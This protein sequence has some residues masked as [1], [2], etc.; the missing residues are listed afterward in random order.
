MSNDFCKYL[1]KRLDAIQSGIDA[2]LTRDLGPNS[3]QEASAALTSWIPDAADQEGGPDTL[4]QQQDDVFSP[5]FSLRESWLHMDTTQLQREREGLETIYQNDSGMMSF[6][7][8]QTPTRPHWFIL[9]SHS[10]ERLCWDF[11]GLVMISLELVTTPVQLAFSARETVSLLILFWATLVYWT[12]DIPVHF[13]TAHYRA[14]LEELRLEFIAKDYMKSWLI[15][16]L[17]IVGVDWA[18]VLLQLFHTASVS[19][20][21][22]STPVRLLRLFRVLRLLRIIKLK[23]ILDALEDQVRSE[24]YHIGSRIF[25]FVI[26]ILCVC[27]F[28]A[29]GWYGMSAHITGKTW[30]TSGGF[31]SVSLSYRYFTALHWSLTQ[32]T[33]ASVDVVPHNLEERIYAVIVLLF[34]LVVFSSFLSSIT[35][36]MTQLRNISS[37]HE[38]SLSLLRRFLYHNQVPADLTIRI[39]RYVEHKLFL[40]KG[41]VQEKDVKLIKLLSPPLHME[42]VHSIRASTL[43]SHPFIRCYDEADT[44]AMKCVCFAAISSLHTS[45]RDVLFTEAT[46]DD[47]MLFVKHG[48]LEYRNMTDISGS[49]AASDG[50]REKPQKPASL[51]SLDTTCCRLTQCD[52]CSEGA[53]WTTWVHF[54]RMCTI[55]D[56]ELLVVDGG[57]FAKQA[58]AH[59]KVTHGIVT[60]AHAFLKRL[61][62]LAGFGICSD[63]LPGTLERDALYGIATH[64]FDSQHFR[65]KNVVLA[66]I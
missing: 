39:R 52:W 41:E 64:S 63:Y 7:G 61:N 14:G 66:H 19:M 22:M 26:I 51:V 25:K 45:A 12:L 18:G 5:V 10:S 20:Q 3:V 32:F 11:L 29:C 28:I 36:A 44:E 47:R 43:T 49:N 34:A 31:A 13:I 9:K 54:G 4:S 57:E 27:H 48:E 23:N 2:L 33:P 37:T 55:E 40:Q 30:I 60:Y 8:L 24:I 16:D 53:L 46:E 56:S 58:A 17:L 65:S 1:E 59:H 6:P 62:E 50:S 42:L 21:R 38:K 15:L 35:A